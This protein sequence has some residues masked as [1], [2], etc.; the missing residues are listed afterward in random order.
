MPSKIKRVWS[1]KSCESRRIEGLL[2]ELTETGS[3]VFGVYASAAVSGSFDV[4]SYQ[5]VKVIAIPKVKAQEPKTVIADPNP[6][7]EDGTGGLKG[8]P[9]WQE[10]IRAKVAPPVKDW[11]ETTRARVPKAGE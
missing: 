9:D 11:Q 7:H 2:N 3:R 10:S 6:D 5:D 8:R 1:F 4:L